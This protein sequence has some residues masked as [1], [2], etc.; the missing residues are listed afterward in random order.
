MTQT[1]SRAVL[2]DRAAVHTRL[3]QEAASHAAVL[4]LREPQKAREFA[5][6]AQNETGRVLGVLC[7]GLGAT[8]PGIFSEG[9][10]DPPAPLDLRAL[11]LLDT[12]ESRALLEL[13]EKCQAAAE[14]VDKQRGSV[15]PAHIPLLPGETT[16]VDFAESVG[17]LT[18]R[19]RGEIFGRSGNGEG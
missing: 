10:P 5:T 2:L 18:Q 15:Y 12:P 6:T 16:G 8:L 19:L 13:L 17:E 9:K 3:A 4:A 1:E 7:D 14:L 11:D